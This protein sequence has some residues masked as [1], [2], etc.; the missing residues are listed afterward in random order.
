M[1]SR[2]QS[3]SSKSC[4]DVHVLRGGDFDVKAGSIFAL[5]GSNGAGKIT[6]V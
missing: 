3:T 2:S 1:H 4:K 5:L 6:L